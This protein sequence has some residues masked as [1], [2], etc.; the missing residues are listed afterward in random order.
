MAEAAARAGSAAAAETGGLEYAFAFTMG[1]RDI[2]R[3]VPFVPPSQWAEENYV[4]MD[5]RFAGARW[6]NSITPYLAGIM[7]AWADPDVEEVYVCGSPQTGKT[8]T[9][10]ICLAYS[11][12]R[13]PGPKM[14][15]MAS[16]EQLGKNVDN[17]LMP[18][19]RASPSLRGKLVSKKAA[20][21]SLR[22]GSVCYF[23]AASS[24]T[25]RAS[26]TVRDLFL[27]EP[28]LYEKRQEKADPVDEF[29]ERTTSYRGLRKHLVISKPMGLEGE[30][31]IWRSVEGCDEVRHFE[32]RCPA[33]TCRRWQVMDLP[34][35][36]A[37]EGCDGQARVRREKLGRYRC[38]GCGMLWS[39]HVRDHVV[40]RGRWRAAKPVKKPRTVGFWLPSLISPFASL[41][42][43][44]ADHLRA[45][46][47]DTPSRWTHFYNS[48]LARPWRPVVAQ[49]PAERVMECVDHTQPPRVV[50]A[51]AAYLTAGIDMQRSGYF[52]AVFAWAVS[53]EHWMIDYGYLPD[54]ES[55]R[56]LVF[57]TRYEREGGGET[58]IHRAAMDT[59]GGEAFEGGAS[60]TE[61]A[62]KFILGCPSGRLYAVKGAPRQFEKRVLAKAIGKL[63]SSKSPITGGFNLFFLDTGYFKELVHASLK[64]DSA[65]PAHLHA[66]TGQDFADQ[67]SAEHQVLRK[68]KL[69]W[70]KTRRDNHYLDCAV[71]ARAAAS[72]EWPPSLRSL[73]MH[74]KR[75]EEIAKAAERDAERQAAAQNPFT[76][77]R[78]LYG[79][80]R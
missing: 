15:A 52:F 28:D 9:L 65:H 12:D 21:M 39:D 4:L 78:N 31:F 24:E 49:T 50:P 58:I 74:H 76:R 19:L 6:R 22:D 42:E 2:F 48:R 54:F 5:G 59:G 40:K 70:E 77:G 8:K 33:V 32:V 27:D 7:D 79:R 67:I 47:E 3:A 11:V 34:G 45:R 23:A 71:Y 36:T 55:V 69:A 41:S 60:M 14:L 43:I 13:R 53:G 61:M 72:V 20:E 68:G 10:H 37:L 30:S 17:K 29:L 75:Q 1:E 26:V 51:G 57:E 56:A 46:E 18:D 66:Q 80:G 25:Q 64:V 62:Y 16:E 38:E 44:Q 35:L 63:P 73:W